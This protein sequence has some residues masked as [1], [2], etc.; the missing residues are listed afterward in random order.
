MS[1]LWIIPRH[2]NLSE[3]KP[4]QSSL[5]IPTFLS[6]FLTD[7]PYVN[8]GHPLGLFDL[9]QQVNIF[10]G[11][12]FQGIRTTWPTHCSCFFVIYVLIDF[13]DNFSHKSDM[14]NR[15]CQTRKRFVWHITLKHWLWKFDNNLNNFSVRHQHSAAY[16]RM[17]KINEQ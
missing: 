5:S 15:F 8:F 12:L 13:N 14:D 11:N 6:N 1:V 17:G 9:T 2:L 7:L 16:N 4:Y 10:L 3:A